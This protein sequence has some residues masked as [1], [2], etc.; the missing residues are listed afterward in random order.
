MGNVYFY[1]D[2]GNV[3]NFI[4]YIREL[5]Y[6]SPSLYLLLINSTYK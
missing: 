3:L 2:F 5:I 6:S 1:S 4:I